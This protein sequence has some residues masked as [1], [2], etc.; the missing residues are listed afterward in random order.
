MM[1]LPEWTRCVNS[2][3]RGLTSTLDG[4]CVLLGRVLIFILALA[5]VRNIVVSLFLKP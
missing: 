2:F 3:V 5:E 4:L 1:R